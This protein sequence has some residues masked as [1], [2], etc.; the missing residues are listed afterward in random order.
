MDSS[1]SSLMYHQ[2]CEPAMHKYY[3]HPKIFS[4]QMDLFV[5]N[6]ICSVLLGTELDNYKKYC[7][8]SFDDG[9]KSNLWAAEE[10]RNRGLLG[11]FYV[12]KDFSLSNPDYL[13]IDDIRK[14]QAM[15]HKIGV[16]GKDHGWWTKKSPSQLVSE[17]KETKEWIEDLTGEPCITCSAV[18]GF[19]NNVVI[20]I[21]QKE[22][23]SLKYIRTSK[24]GVNKEGDSILKSID[25]QTTYSPEKVIKIAM[26]DRCLMMELMT[27]YYLKEILKPVYKGIK[28]VIQ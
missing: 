3:V 17:L 2:V 18:G 20:G 13:D 12:I 21:I 14:I 8:L 28:L 26:N 11:Y 10:L 27:K 22:L 15:G 25:I 7:L 4:K 5:E 1:F 23:P 24:Y 9:H 19:I 16:H 6:N